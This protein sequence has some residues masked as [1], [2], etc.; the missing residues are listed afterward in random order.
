MIVYKAI[1][2]VNG[3][4]YIGQ[5]RKTLE[6]RRNAHFRNARKGVN[7][8]FY[9][10]IRKYGEDAFEFSVICTAETKE[11]L[12]LLE[13]YYIQKY[14]SIKCGYNMV[15]GGDN[16]VMDIEWVYNKH[17]QRMQSEETRSKLSATMKQKIAEGR[18]FTE[19]HRK[20]LSEAAKGNHNF[21]SGDTRSIGCYCILED[22]TRH[23]FH[24]YRDAWQWWKTVDNPFDT[25]A[26]CVYQRKIKQSITSGY[27][28]YGHSKIKYE[29]PKWYK[30]GDVNEKVTDQN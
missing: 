23:D 12:N 24:S 1:N 15:D 3:K 29:Y 25:Q 13:T 18:F 20:R 30:G 9:N 5:T 22:S 27:Y 2:K 14:N 26:E 17:K 11:D 7:T 4:I 16:N 10:A 19:E 28:T 6:A 8:H 21:G